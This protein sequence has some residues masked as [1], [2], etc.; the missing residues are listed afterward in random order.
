MQYDEQQ[1]SFVIFQCDQ[2]QLLFKSA[3]INAIEISF[4]VYAAHVNI[5]HHTAKH[6]IKQEPNRSQER[7]D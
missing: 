7:K 6:L 2:E 5:T 1:F 3:K 4:I